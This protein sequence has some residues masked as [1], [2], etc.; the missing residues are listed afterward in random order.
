MA[1]RRG[2]RPVHAVSVLQL[3]QQEHRCCGGGEVAAWMVWGG[4]GGSFT[5]C[6][7]SQARL[8]CPSRAR[9]AA[10]T[11]NSNPLGGRLVRLC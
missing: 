1:K 5:V 11:L 7:A 3:R 6:A 8:C 9:I 2:N 10:Q 4:E